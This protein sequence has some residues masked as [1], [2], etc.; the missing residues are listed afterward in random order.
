MSRTPSQGAEGLAPQDE[1]TLAS[2]PTNRPEWTREGTR[3]CRHVYMYVGVVWVGGWV[4]GWV[5]HV[6]MW[7]G[8][9]VGVGGWVSG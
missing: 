1:R 7:K 8:E 3:S 2:R 4:G 6:Y 5:W 9:Q